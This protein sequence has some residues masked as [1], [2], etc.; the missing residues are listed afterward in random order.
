MSTCRRL[1]L[2][3]TLCF[4]GAVA[5]GGSGDARADTAK[6]IEWAPAQFADGAIVTLQFDGSVVGMKDGKVKKGGNANESAFMWRLHKGSATGKYYLESLGL[7]PREH[8][9]SIYNFTP[10]TNGIV[11]ATKPAVH[12]PKVSFQRSA[13]L[14]ITKAKSGSA[15]DLRAGGT[16]LGFSAGGEL[17]GLFPNVPT[18]KWQVVA[19]QPSRS[20]DGTYKKASTQPLEFKCKE[21][22]PNATLTAC[23][24]CPDSYSPTYPD[25]SHCAGGKTTLTKGIKSTSRNARAWWD[26]ETASYYRCSTGY[27]HNP[28]FSASTSGVCFKVDDPFKDATK[29]AS[30][31]QKGC[32]KGY[33]VD[34]HPSDPLKL[35]CFKCPSDA[36]AR[37]W[38]KT[39]DQSD[40]CMSRTC[41]AEGLRP[42]Q[43]T[44]RMPSCDEGLA[45]DLFAN[46][47]VTNLVNT[48]TTIVNALMVKDN[49]AFD[50]WAKPMAE[51]SKSTKVDAGTQA[52]LTKAG[53]A[54][55]TGPGAKFAAEAQ[56]IGALVQGSQ[57]AFKELFSASSLCGDP[58]ALLAKLKDPKFR[59]RPDL[60]KLAL[61]DRPTEQRF[62]GNFRSNEL[63]QAAASAAPAATS[64]HFFMS[65]GVTGS[66]AAV[67]GEQ[68]GVA[69]VTDFKDS[70]STVFS[71]GPQLQSDVA[72]GVVD[73]VM[74]YPFATSDSFGGDISDFSSWSWELGLGGGEGVVGGGAVSFPNDMGASAATLY[75]PRPSGVGV[76]LGVGLG[77]LPIAMSASATYSMVLTST[78]L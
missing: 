29:L 64:P 75:E 5:V 36:P 55:S 66:A 10:I 49:P 18:P 45:E 73:S 42:C 3:L 44:E 48:C 7:D 15:M 51:S 2:G 63:G 14:E 24:K 40:A 52:S 41:G 20:G 61:L 57:K 23:Y 31:P 62:A 67:V 69:I 60:S 27:R 19:Y 28:V 50:A 77:L 21:G 68:L 37:D 26:V 12:A 33:Q 6:A 9:L 30:T 74:F 1:G 70:L 8:W 46:K 25:V 71:M 59:F 38:T 22:V 72:L 17:V 16:G 78:S 35:Q 32:D 56:R 54:F 58:K 11:A 4:L 65:L 13:E 76:N 43:I 47:C 39:L 53:K 34:L